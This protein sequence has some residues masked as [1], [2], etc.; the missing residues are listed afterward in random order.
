M[1]EHACPFVETLRVPRVNEAELPE[2]EMMAEFVAEGAQEG[3]KRRDLLTNRRSHPHANQHG[4][5]SIVAK[6][7]ECPMLAGA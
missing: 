1:I 3:A 5:G 7:F 4:V 6:E 2:V